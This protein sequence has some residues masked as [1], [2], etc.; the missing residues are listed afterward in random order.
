METFG[1]GLVLSFTD[2]ASSGMLR[3][4]N[5]LAHLEGMANSA[6]GSFMTLEQQM[7]HLAIAGS[8]L[9]IVG[10]QLTRFGG[11]ML[12]SIGS[13]AKGVIDVG[14][15]FE[16]FRITLNALYKDEGKVS[17]QM[18][19]L[20]NFS[21]ISPF[22]VEDTKDLLITLKSQGIEAF[23][24]VKGEISGVRQENLAWLGDLMTFKPEVPVSRW[25][26]ALQNFI[27]SGESKVLRNVLDMGDIT[28]ILGHSLGSTPLE[29]FK[30]LIELIEKKDL[31]GLMSKNMGTFTQIMSNVSDLF[32]MM[33]YDI[34]NATVGTKEYTNAIT[35]LK[36]TVDI[37]VFDELKQSLKNLTGVIL[38][39][40]EVAGEGTL[41]KFTQSIA[42][43]L[44][45]IASPL[46]SL[47][48][49]IGDLMGK[50]IVLVGEHPNLTKFAL[51]ITAIAG[52][53]LVAFGVMLQFSGSL[54][55]LTAGLRN[56]SY[57]LPS[58]SKGFSLLPQMFLHLSLSVLPFALMSALVYIAWKRNLL[59][60]QTATIETANVLG[61]CFQAIK[62]SWSGYLTDDQYNLIKQW[63]LIE[64]ISAVQS[65]K[66]AVIEMCKGIGEGFNS[67]LKDIESVFPDIH[68]V[69]DSL[70]ETIRNVSNFISGI[71][72]Y[73]YKDDFRRL[74]QAIG[75]IGTYI[76]IAIP[77]FKLLSGAILL[78]QAP[79]TPFVVAIGALAGGFL[80]VKDKIKDTDG[81]LTKIGETI[82]TVLEGIGNSLDMLFSKSGEGGF[83][84]LFGGLTDSIAS[85]DFSPLK[86][87]LGNALKGIDFSKVLGG[88]TIGLLAI[89]KPDVLVNMVS[90]IGNT[91]VNP[92]LGVAKGFGSTFL[93][94]LKTV[95]IKGLPA[96]FSTLGDVGFLILNKIAPFF[97][98]QL[99]LILG[100]LKSALGPALSGIASVLGPAFSGLASVLGPMI[101]GLFS[102]LIGPMAIVGL[103]LS[104]LAVGVSML[105]DTPDDAKNNVSNFFSGLWDKVPDTI[106]EPLLKCLD[107]VKGIVNDIGATMGMENAWESLKTWCDNIFDKL[108]SLGTL[109]KEE[110]IGPVI[111]WVTEAWNGWL[112]ELVG[113]AMGFI[114]RLVE[115][116]MVILPW[117]TMFI[118]MIIRLVRPIIDFIG[119]TIKNI[120]AV[121][122]GL[123][124]FILGVF[125]GDW[126][127][128]WDGIKGIFS[129]IWDEIKG[130][131]ATVVNLIIGALNN[132]LDGVQRTWRKVANGII[133]VA[134]KILPEDKKLKEID[135]DAKIFQIETVKLSTGGFIKDEGFAYLHPNE[136][137]V[138]DAL[139]QSLRTFLDN[140]K[141]SSVNSINN[142]SYNTSD[143]TTTNVSYNTVAQS[144][145][146]SPMQSNRS[147]S[148]NNSTTDNSVVFN[149]GSIVIN[150]Q[151]G[152]QENAEMLAT[153]I[154]QLIERKQT[155]RAMAIRG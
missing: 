71:T 52:A 134:N 66:N 107:F 130:V 23:D 150:V 118:G 82:K 95:L 30:D 32:A 39:I 124:D 70:K 136:V 57:L 92:A 44:H 48:K 22:E 100:A 10:D 154:M 61:Q 122:N 45:A 21:A 28:Q 106:K 72:A 151:N 103:I 125:T 89:F 116:F 86:E 105:G 152:S 64:L 142:V 123:I 6:G 138:N 141:K 2:N 77:L 139:T 25:K 132:F 5:N 53:G 127:R 81:N 43:G 7:N 117:V 97:S 58:L 147:I 137:V 19:K 108:F 35:G 149:Q 16:S 33:K 76:L 146:L 99:S 104:A 101:G 59:G 38:N 74:G 80:Y 110:V 121:F 49:K 75:K 88:V 128:A 120:I 79:F 20:M 1:L 4:A 41:K 36:E 90:V 83:K 24:K 114:G 65:T 113:Q 46:A 94:T 12:G 143:N 34:A 50:L 42:Q 133:K 98:V 144:V 40:D 155:L 115:V 84:D 18:D 135:E 85:L 17:E 153:K 68:I 148:N 14:S 145:D 47:T 51:A 119:R 13:L 29:R 131:V 109:I 87:K 73:K 63:G 8:N 37:K 31:T 26:L 55:M 112:G 3:A 62:M 27:G 9:V 67:I 56:L 91:L 15:E 129:A 102:A 78:A 60:I 69:G 96:V 126:D 54:Y 140:N 111:D 11:A 93:S